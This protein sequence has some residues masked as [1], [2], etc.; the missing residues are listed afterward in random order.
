MRALKGGIPRAFA[1]HRSANGRAYAAVC[2]PW[3]DRFGGRVPADARPLLK[4]YGRLAGIEI[5]RLNAE[6]DAAVA[7]RR[8]REAR[9]LRRQLASMQRDMLAFERRLHEI[10]E[11][12]SR[13]EWPSLG[14]RVMEGDD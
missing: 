5:D 10:V 14:A 13:A 3:V 1:S 6:L 4:Q 7:R 12:R 11:E 8:L 2:A 9:R